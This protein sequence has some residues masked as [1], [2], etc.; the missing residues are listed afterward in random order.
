MPL[1]A[2][3]QRFAGYKILLESIFQDMLA[4]DKQQQQQGEGDLAVVFD[5]NVTENSAYSAVLAELSGERVWL[6]EYIDEDEEATADTNTNTNNKVIKWIDGHMYVKCAN[7]EWHKIRACLRYVTQKPW[8][9]LPLNSKTR[10]INPI[11]ACLA[12]GRNK[13]MASYAYKMFNKSQRALHTGLEIR[14]PYSLINVSKRDIPALLSADQRFAGKAVVKVPY[15][16][17]GQGTNSALSS[18]FDNICLK[19]NEFLIFSSLQSIE[20]CRRLHHTQRVRAQRLHERQPQVRQVH[21]AV[22]DRRTIVVRLIIY[23]FIILLDTELH[24]R[25]THH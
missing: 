7:D 18:L 16:N 24:E 3:N 21:R 4:Q 10:M 8:K 22:A 5:K 12:G 19:C 20:I 23:F 1:V 11:I 15:G 17:C 9:K 13:I 25:S 2:E 14:M 6:V